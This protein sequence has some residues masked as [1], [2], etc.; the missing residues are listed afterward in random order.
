MEKR[1]MDNVEEKRERVRWMESP[2]EKYTPT[3][4]SSEPVSQCESAI[5]LREFRVGLCNNL[6]G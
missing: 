2:M 1:L 3:Y 5:W 6:E 4:V